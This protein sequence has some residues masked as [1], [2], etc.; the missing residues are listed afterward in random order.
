M[1]LELCR[2]YS[3]LHVD[4]GGGSP[5]HRFKSWCTQA[6]RC[7]GP[8]WG[9]G[10][11]D[12]VRR[13]IWAH[14]SSL[15]PARVDISQPNGII[16]AWGPAFK[17]SVDVAIDADG[18]IG[19]ADRLDH[20]VIRLD[21][22]G[23]VEVRWGSG[24]PG[25]ADGR[26]VTAQFNEPVGVAFLGKSAVI[27]SF[28]GLQCGHVSIVTS[29]EFGTEYMKACNDLY[30]AQGYVHPTWNN[31]NARRTELREEQSFSD[32]AALAEGGTQFFKRLCESRK[33]AVS[34]V[35]EGPEGTPCTRTVQ[36]MSASVQNIVE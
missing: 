5:P 32:A 2:Y 20:A 22:T 9:L 14:V 18:C 26:A 34:R 33:T 8:Y 4:P 19:I 1:A 23:V 28:G 11:G 17:D 7:Y 10:F 12:A 30:T 16:S 24:T 27:S 31:G 13:A 35:T 15:F 36:A 25:N 21:A 29:V 3:N 6:S